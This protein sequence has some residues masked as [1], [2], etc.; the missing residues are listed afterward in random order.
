MKKSYLLVVGVLML[1]VLAAVLFGG[2]GGSGPATTTTVTYPVGDT[3]AVLPDAVY[4]DFKTLGKGKLDV[5]TWKTTVAA[6]ETV[7]NKSTSFLYKNEMDPAV[8]AYW[9]AWGLKKEMHDANEPAL[10]WASY[11]P[12]KALEAGNTAVY[13]VVFDFVGAERLIFYAESHGV[14]RYGAKAGYITICP[15]NPVAMKANAPDQMG[16]YKDLTPGQQIVRIL[17]ALE[18]AGYPIDRSRVYV[19]GMSMGGVA[20][21]LSGLEIP[22]LIAAVAP[23]SGLMGLNADEGGEFV[24][25]ASAYTKAMDY[26]MP[27]MAWAGDH[28]MSM[29]PLSTAGAIKGLDLWLQV[30]DCPTQLDPAATL[31]AQATSTDAAVKALGVTGDKM[32]TETIDGVVHYG[33]EFNRSDGVKM[34]EIVCVTNL[35]HMAS[36][37]YARMAWEFMSRFSRDADGKL[38]VAK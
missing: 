10:K 24:T 8:L 32:W 25:P 13:P 26:Q 12:L 31:A 29:L 7:E 28:D 35:P 11:T 37:A 38:V 34:V 33:A 20:T 17:D 4:Q 21:L 2:C 27:M 5:E 30:N 18:A 3:G 23:H 36:S 16:A 1:S 22:N 15:S 19:T 6:Q 9:E 14:A